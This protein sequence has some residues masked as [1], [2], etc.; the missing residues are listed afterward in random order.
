MVLLRILFV[1]SGKQSSNPRGYEGMADESDHGEP[2]RDI[3]I[4]G[5]IVPI[6]GMKKKTVKIGLSRGA[7][8]SAKPAGLADALFNMTQ[9]RVLGLLFGQPGRS[10]YATELIKL[11]AAGSGA[12]QR[13]LERLTHGGL[14]TVRALGKQKHYQANSASLLFAEL[15]AIVEKTFGLAEPVREALLPLAGK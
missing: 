3:P 6:M 14:V 7:A 15:S 5:I 10:Y 13:E 4:L 9:Q 12:V 2:G 8:R 11:A 1:R